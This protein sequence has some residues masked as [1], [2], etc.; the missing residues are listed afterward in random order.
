MF[1]SGWPGAGLLVLRIA[2]GV[3]MLVQGVSF[4]G[5]AHNSGPLLWAIGLLAS[6][7]G[8]FL[9]FGYLTPIVCV[10]AGVVSL[11]SKFFWFQTSS[12][13]LS[14]TRI[15]TFLVVSIAIALI[16]LGPGLFSIDAR[17]FGRREIIIP[18]PSQPPKD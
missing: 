12:P 14:E 13:Y 8:I 9:L 17:L 11:G 1:P 6:I 4:L 16:C 18:A 2:A 3:T 15:A 5:T 7:S 10:L